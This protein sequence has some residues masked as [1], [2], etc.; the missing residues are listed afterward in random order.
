MNAFFSELMKARFRH[1]DS[2]LDSE[3][4]EE[5]KEKF[6]AVVED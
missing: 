3:K 1:L 4:E 2:Q 6:V 5:R